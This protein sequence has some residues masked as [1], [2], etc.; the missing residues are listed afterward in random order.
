[1]NFIQG[2]PAF[3]HQNKLLYRC[4]SMVP[5]C[6]VTLHRS[7]CYLS[8]LQSFCSAL[9]QELTEYYRLIAVLEA[10]QQ[11]AAVAAEHGGGSGGT[12]TLRRLV[13]WTHDPLERLKI[14]A[15]LVDGC[16]RETA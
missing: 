8:F 5:S 14:L 12:L 6:L 7:S 9:T 11:H 2:C 3:F 10:Q 16:K 15:T 13:V 1:M 4:T